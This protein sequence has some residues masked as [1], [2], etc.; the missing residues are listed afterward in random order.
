MPRACTTLADRA[1]ELLD[2]V[3]TAFVQGEGLMND[4][5]GPRFF[6]GFLI[7]AVLSV[8]C[9]LVVWRLAELVAARQVEGV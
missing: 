6:Q 3:L 5:D 4:P 1:R 7:A 8:L 2:L 9:W